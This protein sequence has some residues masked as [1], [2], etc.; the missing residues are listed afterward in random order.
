MVGF[1][2]SGRGGS[3]DAGRFWFF[4]L[5]LDQLVKE[6]LAGDVAEV[7]VYRGYTGYQIATIARRLGKTAYLFDTFEG[8]SETDLKGIDAG[9]KKGVFSDV[10][11]EAVRAHVGEERVKFI[12]GFFP[13]TTTQ[14]ESNLSFCLVHIDCDLYAPIVSALEY[15]YPRMVPGGFIVVHDYNSLGWNGAEKAVDDFFADKAEFLTPLQDSAGSAVVRKA[16]TAGSVDNWRMRQ[17]KGAM[18]GE[19]I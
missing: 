4:C 18:T 16:K 9:K 15:F 7:G 14:I 2:L 12:K 13:E 8:F 5:L 6:G 11:F 19:W 3:G 17:I 1:Y 10:L